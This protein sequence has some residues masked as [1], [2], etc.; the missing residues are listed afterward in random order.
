MAHSE[1]RIS[2]FPRSDHVVE[3][4]VYLSKVSLAGI[5]RNHRG[6]VG[7]QHLPEEGQRLSEGGCGSQVCRRQ[8][9]LSGRRS[10]RWSK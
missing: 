7:G 10:S 1:R 2:L 5:Q 6:V 8:L 3:M 4:C 9:H